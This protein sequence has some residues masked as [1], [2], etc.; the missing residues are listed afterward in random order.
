WSLAAELERAGSLDAAFIAA[1][2]LGFDEFIARAREWPAVRAAGVCGLEETQVL[3]LAR[4]LAD[5]EPVVLAPGNGLERGRNG[6]SGMGRAL[7]R[8]ALRGNAG[9]G[10]GIGRAA[11]TAFPKPPARLQRPDRTPAGPRTLTI[12]DIGRHLAE[13]DIAPP[14][15]ALF[16]YNHNPIVVHPDQNPIRRGLA[17]DEVFAVGI[18]LTMTE[19][20]AHGALE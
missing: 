14:L 11:S 13:D 1:N 4:W 18:E 7:R 3:T 2:V 19:S 9:G 5:A 10:N 17:R 20:M 6:G 15:R 12:N 8:P 16:I